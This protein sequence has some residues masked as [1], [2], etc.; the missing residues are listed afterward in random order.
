MLP[1]YSW[2]ASEAVTTIGLFYRQPLSLLRCTSDVCKRKRRRK[3]RKEGDLF[4][5]EKTMTKEGPESLH[6]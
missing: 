6:S 5:K 1:C 3:M 4:T 2:E